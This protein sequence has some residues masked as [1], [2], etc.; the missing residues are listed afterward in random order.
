MFGKTVTIYCVRLDS[1]C[2]I[3]GQLKVRTRCSAN[4]LRYWR[5]ER[6]GALFGFVQ[7]YSAFRRAHEFYAERMLT[8][9]KL[10]VAT[11]CLLGTLRQRSVAQ[12]AEQS[13]REF[14]SA[15]YSNYQAGG[16]GISL[17]TEAEI[18]RYFASPLATQ[19]IMARGDESLGKARFIDPFVDAVDW[20]IGTILMDMSFSGTRNAGAAITFR[21]WGDL[22]EL[23]VDLIR[24]DGEWRIRAIVRQ[25]LLHQIG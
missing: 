12:A 18:R 1:S 23:S 4:R 20:S 14:L 10:I 16:A 25:H 13:A 8:R 19:I 22:T 9:R 7:F 15:I 21:N 11:A 24:I 17:R 2:R 3:V 6:V 5:P